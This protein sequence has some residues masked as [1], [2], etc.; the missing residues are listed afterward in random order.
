MLQTLVPPAL[1]LALI[2]LLV[3][4]VQLTVFMPRGRGGPFTGRLYFLAWRLW[5]GGE[6][7]RTRRTRRHAG[8]FGP[9]LPPVTVLVWSLLLWLGFALMFLPWAGEFKTA[10]GVVVF[11]AWWN[12]L[13]ISG[14]SITTLGLGDV[15]PRGASLRMLSVL[16]AASGFLLVSVAVTYLMGVYGAAAR[17][18]AL[19]FEIHRFVGRGEGRGPEDLVH[20]AVHSGGA[21]ELTSWLGGTATA[22]SEVVQAEGQYPLLNYFHLPDDLALPVGLTDLLEITTICRSLLDPEAHPTLAV[23]LVT[24]GTERV[25][26]GYFETVTA[27]FR[28]PDADEATLDRA[29]RAAFDRAW[30]VLENSRATLR[31][32][33]EA[34]RH[35]EM[36][37]RTWDR[38]CACL[39]ALFGYP[40]LG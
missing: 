16:A 15:L 27:K 35:Y 26:R 14:Y 32:R 7:G 12:A 38:T 23:G 29:R 34:W 24:A 39:R 22:L 3:L 36:E 20:A 17:M 11:S 18:T 5:T 28:T 2:V 9:L 13:Y 19:A 25:A 4:D 33:E 6:A 8:R 10:D 1:G 30:H 31:P 37:R 40:P 21:D